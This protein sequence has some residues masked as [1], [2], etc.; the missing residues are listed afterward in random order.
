M[1]FT[2][3]GV[4]QA[5]NIQTSSEIYEIENDAAD[6]EHKIEAA[7]WAI[8]PWKDQVVL[9]LGAGT[10][11]HVPRFHTE[12][13]HVF[14]M[15]PHDES[16]LK[17]MSRVAALNM[18]HVSV[19]AGSAEQILLPDSSIDI[20]HARFAYFFGSK[21]EPGL[22]EL[23]RV[24]RPGGTAF[25]IDNDLRNGLFAQWLQRHPNFSHVSAD[26]VE[27]FWHTHGFHLQRI[28]SEWRFQNRADLEAVVKL[29]FGNELGS[30]LL[31]EHKQ[32]EVEY[33]YCLYYRQFEK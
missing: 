10:G 2:L 3:A 24:L 16:R 7:M 13:A 5:P 4:H 6:P 19:M 9:D 12:A 32:L 23:A 25:I 21:N 33:H 15:E 20:V 18:A 1:P 17:I 26:G 8:H 31:N 14:A 11:F 29:E 28:Q 22:V 27:D 30:Q